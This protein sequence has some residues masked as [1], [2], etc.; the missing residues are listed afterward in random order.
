MLNLHFGNDRMVWQG[1][2]PEFCQKV[3]SD[4]RSPWTILH[5][6][7]FSL[8]GISVVQEPTLCPLSLKI[9][10]MRVQWGGSHKAVQCK[11]YFQGSKIK[12]GHLPQAQSAGK[13]TGVKHRSNTLVWSLFQAVCEGWG[14]VW[15]AWQWMEGGCPTGQKWG[16]SGQPQG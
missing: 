12:L 2:F 5:Q 13:A 3:F 8:F 9:M 7:P 1:S 6:Q 15:A 4:S 14:D 16:T 11:R 10:L